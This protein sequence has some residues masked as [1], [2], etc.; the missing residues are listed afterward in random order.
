M[1][2]PVADSPTYTGKRWFIHVPSPH[3]PGKMVLFHL[4]T[5]QEA[6]QAMVD[7]L[8]QHQHTY[9]TSIEEATP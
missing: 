1:P 3:T 9:T 8:D 4:A 2:R 7:G 5:T 6:H